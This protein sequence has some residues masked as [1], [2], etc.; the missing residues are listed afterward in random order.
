MMSMVFGDSHDTPLLSS[1]WTP[2]SSGAYAGTCIFLVVLAIISRLIVAYRHV[3]EVKFHNKAMNRRYV[4]VAGETEA[5]R[6]RQAIGR[7]GE[8]S[9]EATL[10]VRGLDER[11]KVVKTPRVAFETAP[12][13]FSTE[14]PRACVFTVSAGIGYLL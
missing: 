7:G 2:S 5:D 8:K 12:W 13:R 6:E 11:V 1:A 9:D 4:V 3:L 10:T 14:I